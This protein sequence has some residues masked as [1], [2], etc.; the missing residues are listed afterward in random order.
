MKGSKKIL[1]M[2]LA[3]VMCIG[4]LAACGGNNS[5]NNTPDDT[6]TN[7]PGDNTNT[8]DDSQPSEPA[9]D[10]LVVSVEQGLEGK[11]SPFFSLSASDTDI[12]DYTQL[13]LLTTARVGSPVLN[14]I[15]GETRSYN[16]TDYTYTGPANVVITENADGTVSYDITMRDDLVFSDGH[17]C[18]IDDVIFG[19]YVVLD[20]TYDGNSTFFSTGIL[21]VDEYRAGM[22]TKLGLIVAAGEDN[23]DFT[24]WTQEDQ[25]KFWN[26]VN[27]G[28]VKFAQEI[29]DYLIENEANT[30]ED[31]V[32]AC[33]A[34]WGFTLEENATVKDF[35]MAIGENY[36]WNFSQMEAETAGS[37]LSDLFPADIYNDWAGIGIKTG[38]SAPN[39]SGIERTGD[40]SMRITTATLNASAIYQMGLPIVPLHYYGD[41]SL[42]D[43]ANNMFGFPK[44]D[45]SGVKAKTGAPLGAGAYV[46][47][48]YDNGTVY[49]NANPNYYK[50]EPKVAHLQ[51]LESSEANK[52]PGMVAGTL[53]ISD[54]TYDTNTAIQIAQENGFADEDWENFD[55]PVLTTILIDYRGYGYIGLNP[56]NVM[57]GNDPYSEASKNLRKAIATVIAAYRDEAIDSYYG[58]TATVINYPISNTSWAAPQ[59]T[60]DGYQVAYSV[61]VEG[62]PIYAAGDTGEVKYEKALQA[63]IGFLKAAGYK[64]DDNNV[65]TAA[66]D[67][68]KTNYQVNIGAGGSGDH[69]SFL[70]LKNAA[71]CLAKIGFTLNV[72][73]LANSNDLYASYQTGVA[74]MWCA[75]W[76]AASDPDMFQLYHSNG[77]T[78]Y[79]Q[80]SNAELDEL[81][82]AGRASTDQAYRKAT[83]QAAMEIIMDYAVEIPIYQ[84]SDCSLVSTERVDVSS[85]TPNPTPYYGVTGDLELVAVK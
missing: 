77:T 59:T 14:G 69:P 74:E 7:N 19:A 60:D 13:Y 57:V 50:G 3:L 12:T 80:I 51:C 67:G 33:A 35:F 83:Y 9:N 4:M 62:N 30:A 8:P 49:Y 47:Q 52:I 45:L 24:Y 29:I 76:R 22:G 5:G 75:A 65:I 17:P 55:G 66:P 32:A 37:A 39:V 81:I 6:Q 64:F 1:A 53:D 31:S 46:F 70:L 28:G 40:Y 72:N 11:F 61:D 82:M 23:T 84:R 15:E 85:L 16:G 36:G 42:Y 38:D 44:G 58:K 26:A 63:A 20:P 10:T 21:G 54:P 73:D 43:Y 56:N 27:E 41:E 48:S 71:D 18:D 34:N 78:N 2:L 68:A 25:E 79:Y